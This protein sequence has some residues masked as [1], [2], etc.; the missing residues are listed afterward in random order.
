MMHII[1]SICLGGLMGMHFNEDV[2]L[3][4]KITAVILA[5]ACMAVYLIEG[6]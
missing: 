4:R 5:A 1:F 6:Q 3:W 2:P